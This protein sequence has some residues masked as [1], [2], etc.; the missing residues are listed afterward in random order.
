MSSIAGEPPQRYENATPPERAGGSLFHPFS[1]R[2]RPV[3]MTKETTAE[4]AREKV[5]RD[6]KNQCQKLEKVG[7]STDEMGTSPPKDDEILLTHQYVADEEKG[8]ELLNDLVLGIC[9]GSIKKLSDTREQLEEHASRERDACFEELRWKARETY[10]FNYR[11]VEDMA[12]SPLL[13]ASSLHEWMGVSKA[14]PSDNRPDDSENSERWDFFPLDGKPIGEEDSGKVPDEIGPTPSL[15]TLWQIAT[16]VGLHPVL[17]L[18]DENVMEA[19]RRL[20]EYDQDQQEVEKAA[21]TI[22]QTAK[23]WKRLESADQNGHDHRERWLDL[24]EDYAKDIGCG[25]PG[26]ILGARLG[27]ESED[28]STLAAVT[29]FGHFLEKVACEGLVSVDVFTSSSGR[30]PFSV[31]AA[32]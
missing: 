29:R 2:L 27:I 31:P 16:A 9:S 25:S 28:P 24:I 23:A 13:N 26:G 17:F 19:A 7:Y 14:F 32:D 12:R 18:T 21:E 4:E 6:W 22:D 3:S 20:V 30:G 8:R 1:K 11:A 15:K 10:S 5:R